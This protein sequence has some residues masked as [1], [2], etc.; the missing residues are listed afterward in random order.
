M[1]AEKR[2]VEE[3]CTALVGY[4]VPDGRWIGGRGYNYGGHGFLQYVRW[5]ERASDRY[6]CG[7]RLAIW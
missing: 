1:D 3:D 7:E 5:G 2:T 6:G 4:H